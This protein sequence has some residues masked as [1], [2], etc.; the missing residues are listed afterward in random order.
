MRGRATALWFPSFTAGFPITPDTD[1]GRPPVPQQHC[2]DRPTPEETAGAKM[3]AL[4]PGKKGL[5]RCLTVRSGAAN[6]TIT[7]LLQSVVSATVRTEDNNRPL[8][9][10]NHHLSPPLIWSGKVYCAS[11]AQKFF[12][13]NVSQTGGDDCCTPIQETALFPT[14]P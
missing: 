1:G 3:A 2:S 4:G 5:L 12:L 7:A 6:P 9:A 13:L 8:N 11:K 10:Y 14:R